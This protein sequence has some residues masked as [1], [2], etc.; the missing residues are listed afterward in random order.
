MRKFINKPVFKQ[1]TVHTGR[2]TEAYYSIPVSKE[3]KNIS[4]KGETLSSD[5]ERNLP[6][7]PYLCLLRVKLACSAGLCKL[8]EMWYPTGWATQ[9]CPPIV[10]ALCLRMGHFHSTRCSSDWIV[11][12]RFLVA[13]YSFRVEWLFAFHFRPLL[14]PWWFRIKYTPLLVLTYFALETTLISKLFVVDCRI[15]HWQ[16][17]SS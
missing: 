10:S 12:R 4:P 1:Q 7:K 8:Y 14:R 5:H 6:T 17:R 11:S 3:F 2:S 9:R 13:Y 16:K 15:L